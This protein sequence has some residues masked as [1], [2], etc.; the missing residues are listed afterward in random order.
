MTCKTAYN[1][2]VQE[3]AGLAEAVRRGAPVC[4]VPI[5]NNKQTEGME[6]RF[7]CSLCICCICP[8]K[9]CKTQN[10][11][12]KRARLVEGNSGLSGERGYW[13]RG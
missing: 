9:R 4:G 6:G 1:L 7:L 2:A 10:G 5:T 8:K 11:G 12:K 3:A 13:L